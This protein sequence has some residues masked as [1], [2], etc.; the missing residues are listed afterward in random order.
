VGWADGTARPVATSLSYRAASAAATAA[1]I[2]VGPDGAIDLYNNG[3]SAVTL[4]V[5]LN[6]AYFPSP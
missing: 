2:P 4:V 5:D 3:S 1:L 6:G